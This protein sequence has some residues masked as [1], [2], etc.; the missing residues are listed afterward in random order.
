[1]TPL[2]H[3]TK[4]VHYYDLN[5][6][7]NTYVVGDIHGCYEELIIA[8]KSIGFNFSRDILFSLGDIV[9]RGTDDYRTM[10]LIEEPW[11]RM[12]LGNHEALHL[13]NY[14]THPN[15]GTYWAIPCAEDNDYEY[16]TFLDSC[17]N[18]PNA[19]ILDNRY[20]LIHA[21]L[22]LICYSGLAEVVDVKE[23]LLEYEFWTDLYRPDPTLWE[24]FYLHNP[25]VAT[26]PGIERVF[27]GHYIQ[28]TVTVKDKTTYLDT[29]FMAPNY[30]RKPVNKLSFALLDKVNSPTYL[31]VHVDFVAKRTVDIEINNVL[32]TETLRQ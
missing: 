17:R 12:I 26:L 6:N 1:M 11:F 30:S 7:G 9:D 2:P 19:I 22:P 4:S 27:H 25:S 20:V 3:S 31:T 23:T 15:N 24:I 32:H 21:A 8:L 18:L 14:L 28:P 29:G 10:S 13:E 16:T 5:P